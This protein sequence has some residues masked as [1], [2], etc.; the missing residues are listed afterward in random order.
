[1]PNAL[2]VIYEPYELYPDVRKRNQ[3]E[4]LK[5]AVF[6]LKKDFND[7]FTSLEKFKEDQIYMIK[8]KNTLI[9][10]LL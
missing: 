10:E 6:E 4:L 5:A 1:M 7:E 9:E 3:I 2:D 8:E